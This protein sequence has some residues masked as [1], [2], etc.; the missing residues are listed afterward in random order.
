LSP[1]PQHKMNQLHKMNRKPKNEHQ[2]LHQV[3]KIKL[4][5]LKIHSLLMIKLKMK[6]KTKIVQKK[7]LLVMMA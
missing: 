5:K 7:N 6:A 3:S 4:K 1:L 2:A